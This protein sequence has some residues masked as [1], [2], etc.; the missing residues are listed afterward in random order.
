MMRWKET[1]TEINENDICQKIL[2][3]I[4]HE[5]QMRMGDI[6]Y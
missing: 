1:I 6:S 3:N 2:L 4:V 5:W